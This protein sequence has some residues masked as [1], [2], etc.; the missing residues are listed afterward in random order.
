M[1]SS[2]GDAPTGIRLV[3]VTAPE[4][5]AR[6]LARSLVE[7]RL[8][9]CGNVIPGVRSIYR[10]EGRVEEADEALLI[11]K[12]PAELEEALVRRIPELHS[13][14]VPEVLVVEAPRGHAPYL[15]W[16]SRETTGGD[17]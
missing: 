11:L 8:A 5:E 7:E 12:A 4:A 13:Y 14:D 15:D 17:S 6:S 9:A 16:V 3:L 10:W 2:A 1:S